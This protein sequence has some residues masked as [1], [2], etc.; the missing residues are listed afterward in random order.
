MSI[1]SY[2]SLSLSSL[3]V[4]HVGTAPYTSCLE[5]GGEGEN[6]TTAKKAWAS[7]Q[8]VPWQKRRARHFWEQG[9]QIKRYL[10]ARKEQYWKIPKLLFFY[11]L[12]G[13]NS[14]PPPFQQSEH[15]PSLFVLL[16]ISS[17]CVVV[18]IFYIACLTECKECHAFCLFAWI[19]PPHPQPS[20]APPLWVQE[21]RHTRLQGRA[22]GDPIPM[23]GQTLWYSK[24]TI[25]FY[26]CLFGDIQNSIHEKSHGIPWNSAEFHGIIRQGIRRNS[27]GIAANSARNTE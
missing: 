22:W 11:C 3:G 19:W 27:A 13:A 5:R 2:L 7:S 12:I 26:M 24:H 1:I 18:C 20:V 6:K 15:A 8:M 10:T 16:Y 14:P 17:L 9:E 21:G 23:K 25:N 4:V